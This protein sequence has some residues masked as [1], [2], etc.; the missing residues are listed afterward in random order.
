[1]PDWS[2]VQAVREREADQRPSPSEQ[3]RA[4]TLVRTKLEDL[5]NSSDWQL[6]CQHVEALIERDQTQLMHIQETAFSNQMVGDDLSRAML[7]IQY[8]RGRCDAYREAL[9]VPDT[10]SQQA[11]GLT[12]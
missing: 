1:M 9:Q 10:V 7:A 2:E 6:F 3:R 5:I 11:K 12:S 4:L 8:L